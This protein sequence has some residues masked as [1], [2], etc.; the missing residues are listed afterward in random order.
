MYCNDYLG[1][2]MSQSTRLKMTQFM[3]VGNSL[4]KATEIRVQIRYTIDLY[5]EAPIV[6]FV[7]VTAFTQWGVSWLSPVL[8]GEHWHGDS[9]H[10]HLLLYLFQLGIMYYLLGNYMIVVIFFLFSDRFLLL[11]K[12]SIYAR[13]VICIHILCEHLTN[14]I[15][16]RSVTRSKNHNQRKN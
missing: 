12:Q 5:S 2:C 6:Y 1:E 14:M 16:Q 7:P 13:S 4:W 3:D 10:D 15:S 11:F 9:C 8:P